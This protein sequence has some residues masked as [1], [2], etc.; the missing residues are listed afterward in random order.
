MRAL[1]EEKLL[2]A[3]IVQ[4]IED[5]C[6]RPTEDGRMDPDARTAYNFLFKDNN[7]YLELLDID[8]NEFRNRLL[9]QLLSTSTNRPFDVS[10]RENPVVNSKKRIFRL[11]HALYQKKR[12]R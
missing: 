8:I 3:V 6:L 2:S 9:S 5:V 12:R 4:A 1:P 10:N 11:N 7:I